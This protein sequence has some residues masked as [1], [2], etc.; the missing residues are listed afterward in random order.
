MTCSPWETRTERERESESVYCCAVPPTDAGVARSRPASTYRSPHSSLLPLSF[1]FF[2][3]LLHEVNCTYSCFRLPPPPPPCDCDTFPSREFPPTPEASPPPPHP[4][5]RPIPLPPPPQPK[6]PAH[7][8]FTVPVT[9]SCETS[10]SAIKR[11][12][13]RGACCQ[14][15]EAAPSVPTPTCS[16]TIC[17]WPESRGKI[18]QEP[19]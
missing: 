14:R 6:Q 1:F 10:T 15:C 17:L 3:L 19:S 13:L 8:P 11:D 5:P 9:A 12:A 4:I 2:L 18:G 16:S 7:G